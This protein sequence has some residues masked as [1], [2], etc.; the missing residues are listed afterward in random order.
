MVALLVT[1]L[2]QAAL[3]FI[4]GVLVDALVEGERPTA[5][6][7]DPQNPRGFFDFPQ[8]Y[9]IYVVVDRTPEEALNH[10]I[11]LLLILF[12]VS[13]VFALIRAWLFTLA[14]QRVVARLRRSVFNA[15]VTQEVG[16]FDKTRT[17]DM[18]SR[19]TSDTQVIQNA[20]TSNISML[21]R[22][23]VQILV[24]V[25]I[26]F[27]LSWQLSLVMFAV[28]PFVAIGAVIY[29]KYIQKLQK[30]FQDNLAAATSVAEEVISNVRTVRAFSKEARSQE[31]YGQAIHKTYLTGRTIAI[32]FGLFQGVLGFVPQCAIALILWY[33]GTLVLNGTISTGLLTSFL[34]YTL[35]VA[36][37]FAF[38]S[39]LYGDFMAAVG[40]SSKVFQLLDRVPEIP[41][42]GGD[43]IPSVKGR[44]EFRDVSFRY[45]TRPDNPV[46]TD[47][48]LSLQPGQVLALVGPSGGGKTT[49]VALMERF[50]DVTQ[51]EVL[52][53]GVNLKTLDPEWYRSH[54]ALVSQE[55]VLFANTIKENIS[56]GVERPVT[57]EE[58]ED[59]AKAAN[60][61]TFITSFAEGYDTQVGERGVRLSGGQKQRIAIARALLMNPKI[62]LLDEATSA[63]DAESEYYVQDAIE[64][65]MKGRTVL[66][67]AHRLSTVKNA[68]V[69]AVL[70]GGKIVESGNHGQLI[71]KDGLYKKLVSRQMLTGKDTMEEVFADMVKEQLQAGDQPTTTTTT[72]TTDEDPKAVAPSD[73]AETGGQ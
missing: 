8:L 51:G 73:Q 67:I 52:V 25:I 65:A 44:V 9:G 32:A 4:V 46:L 14:G 20:V 31:L 18:T 36:M 66:I 1:S 54:I 60:A 42:T 39:S 53:D 24:S 43:T 49:I 23:L 6:P 30:E 50:Y 55:P 17:G 69:I 63:L 33:G 41:T 70:S 5:I 19:L 11:V 29:G 61:H 12:T 59:V 2:T 13:S 72:T 15:I 56:Y 38:L 58:L 47:V 35:S 57:Q 45:P 40:A 62:L 21:V 16:F 28:V 7:C 64:K 71:E 10:S 22:Y 3:P 68:D 34:L 48:S 26:L 37:A 27:I